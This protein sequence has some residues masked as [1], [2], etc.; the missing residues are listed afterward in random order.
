MNVIGALMLTIAMVSPVDPDV[1]F[2]LLTRD[3]KASI[4]ALWRGFETT[5]VLDAIQFLSHRPAALRDVLIFSLCGAAGQIFIFINI[6]QFGSLVNTIVTIT[7]KF[8]SIFFSLLWFG[9]TFNT[10]QVFGILLVFTGL[11]I[12]IYIHSTKPSKPRADAAPAKTADAGGTAS[13][14]DSKKKTS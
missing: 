2:G 3:G 5:E 7:R 10:I 14:A 6:Q 1:A 13:T 4:D 11:G 9:H 8:F 12:D